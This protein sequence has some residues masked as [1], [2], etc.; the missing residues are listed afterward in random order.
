MNYNILNIRKVEPYAET[1]FKV[2]MGSSLTLGQE[3]NIDQIHYNIIYQIV[4]I[5]LIYLL[6]LHG[7]VLYT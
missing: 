1:E 7:H 2:M 5:Y 3:T 4:F 6:Y